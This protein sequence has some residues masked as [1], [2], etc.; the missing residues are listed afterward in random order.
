[1]LAQLSQDDDVRLVAVRGGIGAVPGVRSAG[2]HAGIKPRKRDLAVIAFD[3]P[4]VCAS[5]ITTNEIKAA[6]V[7]VSAEHIA[8][9]GVVPCDRLQ[10][11]LRQRVH[12]RAR[13][14]R[15]ARDRAPSRRAAQSL[16]ER[17][18]SSPRPA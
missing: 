1:M 12:R 7:L 17:A 8:G 14:S 18:S 16:G 3:A 9:D 4:Q 13:R 10:L 2:V 5:V 15:R 6:P 11:G